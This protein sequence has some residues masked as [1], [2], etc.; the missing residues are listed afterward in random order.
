M[1]NSSSVCRIWPKSLANRALC[2]S[3]MFQREST[4]LQRN[5]DSCSHTIAWD[6]RWIRALRIVDSRH[7]AVEQ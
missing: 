2:A 3:G 1:R 6:Y 7:E 4:L 5:A